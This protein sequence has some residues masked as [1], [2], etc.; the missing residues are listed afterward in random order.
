MSL[1]NNLV[2][3]LALCTLSL[4]TANSFANSV[5]SIESTAQSAPSR[6]YR[7]PVGLATIGL[8][9]VGLLGGGAYGVYA[10]THNHENSVSPITEPVAIPDAIVTDTFD[11]PDSY[12]DPNDLYEYEPNLRSHKKSG[13]G[14]KSCKSTKSQGK[15]DSG[16]GK[17]GSK[18]SKGDSGK[19]KGGSKKGKGSSKSG[20]ETPA[21][22]Y[23][24]SPSEAPSNEPSQSPTTSPT[25]VCGSKDI[26][27]LLDTSETIGTEGWELMKSTAQKIITDLYPN[28]PGIR[29]AVFRYAT[30]V[31]E[32]YTP[33]E[34]QDRE[35]ISNITGNLEYLGGKTR[36]KNA[37]SAAI[38][39]FDLTSEVE[40]QQGYAEIVLLGDGRVSPN[41][42]IPC[43]LSDDLADRDIRVHILSQGE[44]NITEVE[45]LT[46]YG[47]TQVF[48][49]EDLLAEPQDFFDQICSH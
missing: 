41:S 18:S 40:G 32:I 14:K 8:A 33:L 22:T 35:V 31:D 3:S 7:T 29:F 28:N 5:E 30:D 1:K 45:C 48:E 21:P 46:E 2:K 4:P 15:G 26:Y 47:N 37:I 19:G 6:W 23:S 27:L 12:E 13:K 11:I 24:P 20:C 10:A 44:F 43:S 38:S 42:Q 9:G 49:G 16:K 34:E 17:G 36:T 25:A 39:T